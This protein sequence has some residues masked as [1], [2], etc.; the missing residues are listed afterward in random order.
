M[1]HISYAK[2]YTNLD[3][4][5]K[6]GGEWE[7]S[8]EGAPILNAAFWVLPCCGW[9]IKGAIAAHHQIWKGIT[10]TFI[11]KELKCARVVSKM[12]LLE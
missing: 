10:Q 2:I 6:E 4:N 7:I 12:R 5:K 8:Q 9:S 11:E 1:S 3:K